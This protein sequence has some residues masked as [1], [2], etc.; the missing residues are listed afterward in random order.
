MPPVSIRMV[1]PTNKIWVDASEDM[2]GFASSLMEITE[3]Y[4][5]DVAG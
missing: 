5:D 1:G 3:N 2:V 4:P